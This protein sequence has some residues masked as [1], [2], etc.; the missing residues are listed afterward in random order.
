MQ[1]K[2]AKYQYGDIFYFY[3]SPLFNKNIQNDRKLIRLELSVSEH[4][5]WKR[6][7]RLML[8]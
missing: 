2:R 3:V 6:Y 7:L 4:I 8:L 5:Y 1:T